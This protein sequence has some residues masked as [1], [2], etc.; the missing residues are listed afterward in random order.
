MAG[1]SN[2]LISM[3]R[4][5]DN[6]SYETAD[7][8]GVYNTALHVDGDT[9]FSRGAMWIQTDPGIAGEDPFG[10]SDAPPLKLANVKLYVDDGIGDVITL[11]FT[12]MP[13]ITQPVATTAESVNPFD[14]QNFTGE[15]I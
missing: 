2:P 15:I 4:I 9:V 6:Q 3:V 7:G 12:E 11:D 5:K 10:G 8:Q 14:L 1:S 13:L